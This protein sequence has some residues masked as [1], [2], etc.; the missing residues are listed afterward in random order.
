VGQ[1]LPDATTKPI[2]CDTSDG[3][4]ACGGELWPRIVSTNTD[5]RTFVVVA[6]ATNGVR[7]RYTLRFQYVPLQCVSAG[8]FNTAPSSRWWTRPAAAPISTGRAASRRRPGD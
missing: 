1:R 2:A 7:G 4:K 6:R 3:A 5:L 8:A